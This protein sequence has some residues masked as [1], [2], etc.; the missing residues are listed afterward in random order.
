MK[1]ACKVFRAKSKRGKRDGRKWYIV[2]RARSQVEV[3]GLCEVAARSLMELCR[4]PD[5][6]VGSAAFA[7]KILGCF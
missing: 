2:S 7:Q 4:S 5:Q 3:F 6:L 1:D